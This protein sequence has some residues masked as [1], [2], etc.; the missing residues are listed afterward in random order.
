MPEQPNYVVLAD[1]LTYNQKQEQLKQNDTIAALMTENMPDLPVPYFK[2]GTTVKSLHD[3][4]GQTPSQSLLAK[5]SNDPTV[6]ALYEQ[7]AGELAALKK[8]MR[9]HGSVDVRQWTVSPAADLSWRR[10]ASTQQL[11]AAIQDFERQIAAIQSV[12]R[13]CLCQRW[14]Q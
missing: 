1:A 13:L 10:A 4:I 12:I 6:E 11:Q 7:A 2:V 8:T 3:L 9:L 5:A 14:C